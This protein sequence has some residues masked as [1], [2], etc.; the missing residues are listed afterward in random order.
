MDKF[1]TGFLVKKT[2]M[3]LAPIDFLLLIGMTVAGIMLRSIVWVM[4]LED[5]PYQNL[6]Q[7]LKLI[8]AI[9]DF[10][11]AMMAAVLVL[12]FTRSLIKAMLSYGIVFV[13]PPVV[14]SSGVWGMG[15][16]IY[17]FLT[18][19]ALYFL[20]K[21]TETENSKNFLISLMLYGLALVM[22]QYAIFV[23]PLFLIVYLLRTEK[24]NQIFAFLLPVI[25]FG[26]HFVLD[27]GA[28]SGFP[29]FAAEG[30]L[31][32]SRGALL[33]SYNYPNIY[34]LIGTES[35]IHEYGSSMRVLVFVLLLAFALFAMRRPYGWNKERL[36]SGALLLSI[37]VPYIMPFMDER[38]GYLAALISVVYGFANLKRFYVPVIQVTLCYLASAAYFRG[39]SQLPLSYIALVQLALAM[40][41]LVCYYRESHEK[42]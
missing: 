15:D 5:S 27:K 25:G 7:T 3:G 20:M 31:S 1:L 14:I 13:L 41:L 42:A 34:Q 40:Y 23:L 35:Y 32:E 28:I 26:L 29:F 37:C 21:H 17:A 10:L 6:D 30:A 4:P 9:F 8:S 36:L 11:L 18:L 22:N 39:E 38:A 19:A 2:K 33:L 24:G 12:Y 16:S